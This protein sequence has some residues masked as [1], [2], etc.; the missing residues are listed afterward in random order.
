MAEKTSNMKDT[1]VVIDE[2]ETKLERLLSKRRL[3][4][5]KDLE[6]RIRDWLQ[7]KETLRTLRR[8]MQ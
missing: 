1:V 3:E 7:I 4:I 2:I 8:M 6:E 5:E